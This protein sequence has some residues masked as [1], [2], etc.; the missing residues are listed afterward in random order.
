MIYNTLHKFRLFHVLGRVIFTERFVPFK[1]IYW[2]IQKVSFKKKI[3][4]SGIPITIPVKKGVGLM[5]LISRYEPWMDEILPK[6]LNRQDGIFIDVGANIG[7]TI[8]KVLP[9]YKNLNYFAIEPNVHCSEYLHDL[10]KANGFENLTI[11]KCALSNRSGETMLLT[12]F[13]DDILATTSPSFRKFTKYS[14]G[15]TV[16]L[17]T[18]DALFSAVQEKIEVIKIDVE[19]G[20]ALVLEGFSNTIKQHQPKILI[21]ILPLHSVDKLVKEFRLKN[22][23][24]IIL[25]FKELNYKLINIK[26]KHT[27]QEIEDLSDSLESCNYIALHEAKASNRK[28]SIKTSIA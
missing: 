23:H 6:I 27:I 21:E 9:T 8:L 15:M 14:S 12:R 16:P 19:G 2:V 24:K 18:G 1:T 3:R 26:L 7:Q 22:A 17:E 10:A 11:H 13:K 25:F 5:N 20:E 28:H 4:R